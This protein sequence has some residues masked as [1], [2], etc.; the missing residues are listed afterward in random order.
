MSDEGIC[1]MCKAPFDDGLHEDCGG[2]CL[3]CMALVAGDTDCTEKALRKA[4]IACSSETQS[5]VARLREQLAAE[6]ARRPRWAQGFSDDSIAAQCSTN[7]LHEIWEALGVKNQT[8]AMCE[9]ARHRNPPVG[10][11]LIGVDVLRAWGKLEE[12]KSACT[13]PLTS[14]P[15]TANMVRELRDQ[16]D[17]PMH[18]CK[19]A[20]E[21]SNGDKVAA[22]ELIA[23]NAVKPDRR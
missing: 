12:V 2:D 15:I 20:L 6:V 9:I 4:L 21:Q 16:T 1:N 10:Y 5:E 3:L 11:A 22:K 13:Y 17:A 8:E 14:A 19:L 7:A 23:M 18:M